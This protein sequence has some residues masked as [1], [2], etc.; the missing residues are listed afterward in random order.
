MPSM[1]PSPQA[2]PSNPASM[3]ALKLKAKFLLLVL[4]ALLVGSGAYLLYARGVFEPTQELVL[5]ADDSEGVSVG[6]GLTF[7]GFPI[8]RVQR[9]ELAPSGDVHIVVKIPEKD[10]HWLRESSIFTMERN[11]L[12]AVRLRAF[13]GIMDDPTLPNGAVRAVLKGDAMAEIPQIVSTLR[14][15]ISNVEQMTN[16]Q[17]PLASTLESTSEIVGGLAGNRQLGQNSPVV[18]MLSQTESLLQ[19]VE[20]T[21]AQADRRLFSEQGLMLETQRLL[22]DVR[23]SLLHVD[24]IL[25][26]AKGIASNARVA[27]EDLDVLRAQVESSLQTVESLVS[28]IQR[29]WPFG[30]QPSLDLP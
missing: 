21:I 22:S 14:D 28:D 29:Q 19:Q 15:I 24:G 3:L 27:T 9:I 30:S 25:Q 16:A 12:G 13:T 20:T 18:G 10:A 17:S 26:E 1:N 2:T 4:L 23:G 6:M 7:S 5:V 8:G 11:L